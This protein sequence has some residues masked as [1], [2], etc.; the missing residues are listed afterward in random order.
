MLDSK[1]LKY[2]P[3]QSDGHLHRE[4]ESVS[5]S[6][7]KQVSHVIAERWIAHGNPWN[8]PRATLAFLNGILNGTFIFTSTFR[9]SARQI[10]MVRGKNYFR[11]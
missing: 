2:V 6:R 11:G 5:I 1:T 9:V 10:L 7:L 3:E 8:V 4:Y